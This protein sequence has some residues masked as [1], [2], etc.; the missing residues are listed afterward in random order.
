[1]SWLVDIVHVRLG[2]AAVVWK[3]KQAG[4]VGAEHFVKG[5]VAIT[6]IG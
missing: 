6:C 5:E 2:I 1:M 3:F 4:T